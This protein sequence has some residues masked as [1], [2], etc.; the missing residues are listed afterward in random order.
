MGCAHGDFVASTDFVGA[1]PS[2]GLRPDSLRSD[3]G[4]TL[5]EPGRAP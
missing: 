4:G 1:V 2:S 3:P 5:R